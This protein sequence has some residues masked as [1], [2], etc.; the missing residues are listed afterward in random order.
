M[1]DGLHSQPDEI[2]RIACSGCGGFLRLERSIPERVG[3]PRYDMMRCVSCESI[4][5]IADYSSS[6]E[7]ISQGCT[8]ANRVESGHQLLGFLTT[9]ASRITIGLSADRGSKDNAWM[10]RSLIL[11]TPQGVA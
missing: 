8:N 6:A 11:I 9:Q 5:C 7:P 3:H 10:A 2:E 4:Q 1:T